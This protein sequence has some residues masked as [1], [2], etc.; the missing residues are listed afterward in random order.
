MDQYQM[1][2]KQCVACHSDKIQP[3]GLTGYTAVSIKPF[4]LL[5]LKCAVC[6]SCGFVMPYLN[7]TALEKA[8]KQVAS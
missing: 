4:R 6:M 8:R 7:T 3:A 2:P 5:P 1:P